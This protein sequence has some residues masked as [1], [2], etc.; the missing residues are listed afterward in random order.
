MCSL[1]KLG[2]DTPRCLQV[3]HLYRLWFRTTVVYT[4]TRTEGVHLPHGRAGRC[5]PASCSPAPRS[6]VCIPLLPC[7]LATPQHNSTP[8]GSSLSGQ[9]LHSL[10][11]QRNP[12]PTETPLSGHCLRSLAP[13]QRPPTPPRVCLRARAQLLSESESR[14]HSCI[15]LAVV[16]SRLCVLFLHHLQ[17]SI[18][19]RL[20]HEVPHGQK[21][22]F[23]AQCVGGKESGRA[24][25][26]RAS[27]AS[28]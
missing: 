23:A 10:A 15:L 6:P 12:A 2:C 25:R 26:T 18:L 1:D 13:R 7:L 20:P 9:G 14:L 28:R 3:L 16:R 11:P 21:G 5:S 8:A 4:V 17:L 22:V 24:A 19:P 27:N